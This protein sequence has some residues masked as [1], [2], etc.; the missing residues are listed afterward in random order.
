M[1]SERRGN[2]VVD[3][4]IKL[5]KS[6]AVSPAGLL[7]PS[8]VPDAV[9]S[10]VQSLMDSLVPSLRPAA[11]W[12]KER[13]SLRVRVEAIIAPLS[14]ALGCGA[15]G[16]RL[17]GSSANGF[18]ASSSDV[19]MSLV[20]LPSADG[21]SGAKG[22]PGA[23]SEG[24]A[25]P[26][27]PDW[28]G[29]EVVEGVARLLLDAG[30]EDVQSRPTAR[31]PVVTFKDPITG[32][33]SDISPGNPLALRNT[34]LLRGYA[35]VDERLQQVAY[36]V[37]HIAKRRQINKPGCHTLSSYGYVLMVIAFLQRRTPLPAL[38]C[39]QALSEDWSGDD[40]KLEAPR[41]KESLSGAESTASASSGRCVVSN[42][43]GVACDTWFFDP[44]M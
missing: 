8:A 13:E 2:I 23:E 35:E 4:A 32:L 27:T 19:D 17:F 12:T 10:R 28:D 33:D 38:P 7:H 14:E 15:I 41:G 44:R 34:L 21:T 18:G 36:M 1:E 22:L 42:P 40:L 29:P 26:T 16:V 31:V 9:R 24:D 37:K 11:E 25:F 6:L 3:P 20:Q 5:M 39:L 43:E 30:M